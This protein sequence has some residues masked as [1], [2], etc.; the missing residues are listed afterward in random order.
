[1]ANLIHR[2]TKTKPSPT[3]LT[4]LNTLLSPKPTPPLTSYLSNLETPKSDSAETLISRPKVESCRSSQIIFPNFPFGL[5]LS[6]ISPP[7]LGVV[8]SED[9]GTED[10]RT[11]WADST[12]KKRKKKMNKHKLK[13]L[14]KRLRRKA[15][16]WLISPFGGWNERKSRF[17]VVL[18][19]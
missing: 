8:E 16:A 17:F 2:L 15:R 3:L 11:V 12:K 9:V 18:I 10:S 5:C 7:P 6:P 14:R 1:M 4:S 19:L 13:K